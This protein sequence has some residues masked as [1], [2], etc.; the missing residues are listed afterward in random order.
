MSRTFF[1]ITICLHFRY[2]SFLQAVQITL[3]S[4]SVMQHIPTVMSPEYLVIVSSHS[5]SKTLIEM[6]NRAGQR[7]KPGGCCLLVPVPMVGIDLLIST[8]GDHLS[9]SHKT[10]PSYLHQ[11]PIPHFFLQRHHGRLCEMAHG[12][13]D[14]LHR[15]PFPDLQSW[16]INTPQWNEVSLIWLPLGQL[17]PPP[18]WKQHSC[19]MI[20]TSEFGNCKGL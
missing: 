20:R 4:D 6:V 3:N 1:H 19:C 17:T 16:A 8:P 2:G 10:S 5:S 9:T 13:L 14:A 15:L 7:T 11:A 18:K 12:K